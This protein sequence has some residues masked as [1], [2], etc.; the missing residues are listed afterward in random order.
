MSVTTEL[1][2]DPAALEALRGE[3]DALCVACA[4]PICSPAWMLAWWR[5][6]APAGASPRVVAVR[7]GSALIGLAPFYVIAGQRPA[8]YRLMADDFS[9]NVALL[10][11]ADRIWDVAAATGA[12]LAAAHPRPEVV[13]LA[14]LSASKPW[15][16]A[17]ADGWPGRMRPLTGRLRYEET[18]TLVLSGTYDE[19]LAGRSAGF[20]KSVRRRAR[21]FASAGGVIRLSTPESRAEDVAAF[22]SLHAARWRGRDD[23]RLLAL[24]ERLPRLLLDIAG[25]PTGEEERM[26]LF[27]VELDGRPI[28]A[29]L[30]LVAGGEIVDINT[31][32]DE[33]YRRFAPV[34]LVTLHMIEDAFARGE[35]RLHLGWGA[36]GYKR[37]FADG[38]D[39]AIWDVLVPPGGGMPRALAATAP[40]LLRSR[41]R[42]GALRALPEQRFTQLR[43]AKQRLSRQAR[44]PE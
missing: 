11:A 23:S 21:A 31:G 33:E 29:D 19:W 36:L 2:E 42:D 20:R 6:V 15:A 16:E 25:R 9:S 39:P 34:Q 43:E 26:R 41:V 7:D 40:A 3:W 10:A 14:P 4:E 27:I 1:I 38:N 35:R 12:A 37:V 32:W 24:G 18:A 13:A 30:S 22:I 28:G 17:F 5:H 8:T 44:R